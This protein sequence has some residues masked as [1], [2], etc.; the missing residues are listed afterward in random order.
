[1]SGGALARFDPVTREWFTGAFAVPTAAQEGA[2]TSIARGDNTLVVAPTGSGKTLA[3]FLW[4][5]DRLAAEQM[6]PVA[7]DTPPKKDA[8]KRGGKPK[9]L[10]RV[11]YVS[12]LKALAVDVERN[13]RAPLTGIKQTARRL[14]LPVPDISVAI[15]SG[16]TSA[17]DRRRFAANPADIL[18]TTP[19]SLFLILTSQ[20]R[21]ALRGVDTVIIDEVHA[22]APTKRGAHLALSLER[23][24]A[25]L[26]RPAQRIGL[27]ATVRPV[28]EVAAF[29]GGSRPAT[30]V[31]PPSDK[32]IDI[33]VIVPVE[34]MTEVS[35]MPPEGHGEPPQRSIWP[36]V[37]E[38]LLDL[39]ESH[40]STIIF[41]NSRRLSERLCTRLNELAWQ[42][43]TAPASLT[44]EADDPDL[45]GSWNIAD[46]SNTTR[47]SAAGGETG[48]RRAAEGL[49]ASDDP[50]VPGGFGGE[51]AADGEAGQEPVHWSTGFAELLGRGREEAGR[52]KGASG[53][54]EGSS[55]MPSNPPEGSTAQSRSSEGSGAQPQ[56]SEGS[57]ML[58]DS[59]GRPAGS[60]RTPA[61]MMAMAGAS[62]GAVP[63]VVRAHH[64]SVSKEERSQIEEALKSGR[65]PA[66]VATSSL[67]LG[68]DMGAVDLVACVAAPPS[69]ASGL[70]RIGRAGHQVGAVSRGVIFPKYR[71]DLVQTAVVAERMKSGQIEEMRYPRNPLDV[72]AQQI[73]AMTAVDEWTVDEL[74]E[75]VKRAAPYATLPRSALEATLDML[76]GRYPSEEFAELRPRLV[77]DRVTGTLQARPGAQRL[78]VTNGGTIPD[79]GLFGVFL[80]GEKSSRVGE[81]DEEMVYE[82][83]AGDVFVLGATSW[84]IEEI[85]ADRVLVSPAPGQ[86]GKLPFW[87]GDALG[88]PAELG[89]AIGAFVRELS[90]GGTPADERVRAAGLDAFA[91]ANLLA[92]LKEQRDATG[93]VPDD[94]TLLVERF[95]DELGDWRVV[96]HSPYGARVHAP[97]ALALGRRLRER[98]G[99]DVQA[100]HSDDG[101][102]LRVPDT[103][104]DAPSDLAAFDA[105]EIEQ[106]VVEELGGSALFASR[107][108]ECAGRALLLPRRMPGKRSPLWQQRQRAA[109]LLGAA[110]KY[111]SFPVVLE[112]MRECLQDVFD[113]PGLVQLMRDI[114]ARRV[115]VVEVE[116]GQASPFAA[117]LLFNY[118]G[119]FMYEGDAPLAERRAQALA[120]DTSLLAELLGQADLRELLDPDVIAEAERELARLDRPLR[121]VE[122][123]ADLLRSHGPLLTED[124]SIREGDPAWLVDLERTRR[125]IRVRVAGQ[126]QWAAIEDAWRLRDALG[127][128]LP[129]GVPLEFLDPPDTS[130]RGERSSGPD[131]IGDLVAR[132]ACT[133][134]PFD[135]GTAAARFGVG[136]AVINDAL[137]RLAAS[138]RVVTGEFRPGGRG[139]EW[140]D[141]GVLRLLRRRSLA[142]LRKEVEPVPPEVLAA[143][144][145]Q[146]HGISAQLFDAS[147]GRDAGRGSAPPYGPEGRGALPGR[148]PADVYGSE[149]R[150]GRGLADAYGPG[151]Q[152]SRGP[153][154][155]YGPGSRGGRGPAD[156]YGPG[157]QGSRG[158]TDTYGPGSR[159]GR[160]PADAYGQEGRG[161]FQ[162]GRGSMQAMDALV[163]AI[164]RL[165][166]A[167]VPGSALETLVLPGRVPGYSPALLDELTASGEV[168]WAGQ[169]SLPGGDG[170]VSLYF[171][172]TAPLLLPEPA[173]ISMTPLHDLVLDVLGGGGALFFRDLSNRVTSGLGTVPDDQTLAAALWDLVWSGR[174][175]GD[176]LA[177]LRA[178]LGTGRPAHRPATTRRR[179]AV[180]PTRTGPPTVGGRWWLLPEPARDGTQRAHAQA[181]VLLERHGVLT[182][183]GVTSERLPG[184]FSAVYQVLRAFEESGRCRRGYFVEG[185]GGAQ[186]A[187]PGAVDRMRSMAPSGPP[188]AEAVNAGAGLSRGASPLDALWQAG[189]QAHGSGRAPRRTVV[190][191]A[192]DP[193]N[194]YGAALPW[195]DRAEDVTHRPGRKAGALVV[196]VDGRLVLYVERGGK[197]LL[198]FGAEEDLRPAVTALATAVREGALGKLTVE[199]ADGTA[200]TSSPLAAALE[201]AGFHPT[202]R[203]LRI[204]G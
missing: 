54:P 139:E 17:E 191:A 95:H 87:H 129:V 101:I 75:L 180:L 140:C 115:R 157:S 164:E 126:E 31:Q 22:V 201:A 203:G 72:L 104:D 3:A 21:E 12:P 49:E 127:A 30:I 178:T 44:A 70:Q 80:V 192:A 176:T 48:G 199:R 96:I 37:E 124:V 144:L 73:V 195:P 193:A 57:G 40:H 145:P 181:E 153:T 92:Y 38:H 42:R 84:R 187:S 74:E 119:A 81:L 183:G 98:Y 188:E 61:E 91:S 174:V 102:V 68:I 169:G 62:K 159:G 100:V 134:G 55:E 152:G 175:T 131:P 82:S 103:L 186:F 85:T 43:R 118:V 46:G 8:S 24:D 198:S 88:R 161:L 182:R 154:D 53:E 1:M 165:Q 65:L 196:M 170:W 97:W 45:A 32:V 106:I 160:G 171:A 78:A 111:A 147:D 28:S 136:I 94:R 27:S 20:A 18:I 33:D 60:S 122:D 41:A 105:D 35:G 99:M 138:G 77:W 108:R 10:C 6:S 189:V 63:E 109:Q 11:L 125:A 52:P 142:R 23:L 90:A 26:P 51:S 167:A 86:P 64:G 194:P 16:D 197:T 14:G 177:P 179:R 151:S 121:D 9:R 66:V 112:T 116:T 148:S 2:W 93:Y 56:S 107:F 200:I 36:H 110:S 25:L 146:W 133:R 114:A 113:V 29:L 117:S 79:R 150:S 156:A 128:P 172:D 76:A 135:A 67:E 34:D 123:L 120:L 13:L 162:G 7:L 204:R 190:L 71:G 137:R 155:T 58:S 141:S 89:R 184:G 163:H 5:L 158:P 202:P 4:S 39:I 47:S 168:I 130:V 173:E 69:V 59:S 132:H 143:F 149:D 50:D 15:R 83:R 166:G 19:E 185:L